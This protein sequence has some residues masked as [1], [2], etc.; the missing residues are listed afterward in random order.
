MPNQFNLLK[1]SNKKS[2]L[3]KEFAALK[4][5]SINFGDNVKIELTQK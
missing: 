5:K 1:D 4:L 2:N 3:N